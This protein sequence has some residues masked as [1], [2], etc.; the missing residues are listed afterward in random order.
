MSTQ[1]AAATWRHHQFSDRQ[2]RC[3]VFFGHQGSLAAKVIA[4]HPALGTEV[5]SR[6]IGKVGG[7]FGLRGGHECV[8]MGK[9][10]GAELPA[11]GLGIRQILVNMAL[12]VNDGG[13]AHRLIGDERGR[14]GQITEIILFQQ[15]GIFLCCM[16]VA[17]SP[18]RHPYRRSANIGS[19][20]L[21]RLCMV[22]SFPHSFHILEN[23]SIMPK[24]K[25][26]RQNREGTCL[27]SRA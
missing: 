16:L 20:R 12:R 3:P 19:T 18:P 26:N 14:M 7:R 13:G 6:S 21:I 11:V 4:C 25:V 17:S 10:H 8:E 22:C 27:L 23:D 9:K 15:R 2:R 24:L 5:Q 1:P